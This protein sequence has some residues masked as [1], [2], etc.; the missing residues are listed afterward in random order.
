M[1]K[2]ILW[3]IGTVI[4]L[5]LSGC[6]QSIK[7][8]ENPIKFVTYDFYNPE[9]PEDGYRAFDYNGRTYILFS[10]VKKSMKKSDI[11][12]CLGYIVQDG[13]QGELVISLSAFEN[14][15]VLMT[16]YP[17][18]FMEPYLIYRAIDT[19]GQVLSFPDYMDSESMYKFW[20]E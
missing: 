16:Y 4:L 7:L 18:G 15:D 6:G 12:E 20:K 9:N 10:S 13:I 17:N 1:K 11:D 2:N 14:D 3:L 19:K 5:F 8:P